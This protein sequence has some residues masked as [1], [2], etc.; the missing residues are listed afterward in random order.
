M[1]IPL[2]FLRDIIFRAID[3]LLHHPEIVSSNRADFRGE[4]RCLLVYGI[5][6]SAS[7]S[8]EFASKGVQLGTTAGLRD[9]GSLSA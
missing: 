3:N 8:E 4:S 2:R 6:R 1:R 9:N 7:S 5:A